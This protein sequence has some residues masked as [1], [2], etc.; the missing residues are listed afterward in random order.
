MKKSTANPDFKEL[1]HQVARYRAVSQRVPA[2]AA[3][4]GVPGSNYLV[5]IE[6]NTQFNQSINY[7][8]KVFDGQSTSGQ[9]FLQRASQNIFQAQVM[10]FGRSVELP[11]ES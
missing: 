1:S 8:D 4:T 11:E 3:A 2:L 7:M 6:G 5:G 9:S 10:K